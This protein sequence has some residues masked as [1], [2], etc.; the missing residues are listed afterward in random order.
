MAVVS[1]TAFALSVARFVFDLSPRGRP[2]G[3]F[4]LGVTLVT[5][6]GVR[7]ALR[8]L[9]LPTRRTAPREWMLQHMRTMLG[10]C[11]AAVTAFLVNTADNVGSW[12]PAAWLGPAIVGTPATSS[13]RATTGAGSYRARITSRYLESSGASGPL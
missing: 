10:S 5:A 7:A 9:G 6:H 12:A 1:L 13:G 11:I 4:L 8:V 3:I 2:A